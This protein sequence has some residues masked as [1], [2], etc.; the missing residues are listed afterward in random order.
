MGKLR[1]LIRRSPKRF[2]AVVTMVAVAI[3]VPATLLAWGPDRQTFTTA[4]P[5]DYITFNSITDN[6]AHGDERNFMQV[7]EATASNTT[8]ADSISLN[9]GKEYVVYMYYHNNAAANLNLV[10]TGTYAK[11]EIP[12]VVPNGSNG[13]KAVGYIGA[14][15]AKPTQVWDD[16]SF[17]NN[18]GADIALRFV[19]GSATIHS[20]GSVNGKTMADSIATTGAPLGYNALDGKVPGCNEYAGY[21]TF[22]VKAD[23]PDFTVAKTVRVAGT[24]GWNE[25]VAAKDGDTVEYQIAYK[26][27]GTTKQNDVIVQDKL[28]NGI[29]YVPGSTYLLNSTYPNGEKMS[30]KLVSSTGMNIGNYSPGAAGY[31]KFSAKVNIDDLECGENTLKNVAFVYT[32]NG[33]KHDGANVTTKTECP[34]EVKKIKVCDLETKEIVTIN[35]EDFDS[36][37][38]SKNLADCD[39]VVKKIKVCDLKTKQIVTINEEDFDSSKYSKNLADCDE[40]VK[41]IKVCELKTKEIVTI[42]E[43]DFDSSKYS[44]DLSDCDTPETPPELP[45]TGIAENVVA[46]IGLGALIASIAYYIASRRA[47]V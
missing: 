24:S 16:I 27:T 6:P 39:E 43:A 40:V 41:K 14:S 33:N 38:Y 45:T 2:V 36:S 9:A 34:P 4:H 37:K 32:A 25:S 30:D 5:A 23:Q 11:T 20:L 21:V 29:D 12:A 28:P 13:T 7:R 15:N 44:K 31:L 26:N 10:A 19:P 22:R 42:N 17:K 1:A 35:E 3:V 46:V 47:L 18:T 8:Y